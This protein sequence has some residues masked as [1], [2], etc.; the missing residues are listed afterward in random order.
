MFKA[1][2]KISLLI[3]AISGACYI[4]TSDLAAHISVHSKKMPN[5]VNWEKALIINGHGTKTNDLFDLG[6]H[7]LITPD[8]LKNSYVL[9]FDPQRNLAKK[10]KYGVVKPVKN[11]KWT[12]YGKQ[13]SNQ[14]VPDVIIV[15]WKKNELVSFS[16]RV[17]HDPHIWSDLDGHKGSYLDRDKNSQLVIKQSDDSLHFLNHLQAR[18]YFER[19][20]QKDYDQK[21]DGQ[22]IFFYAPGVR[23]IKILA[24]TRLSEILSA[25]RKMDGDKIVLLIAS[26]ASRS[27]NKTL[28]IN[29]NEQDLEL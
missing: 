11:G 6:N 16:S 23:K 5:T 10:I 4:G 22:P 17:L 21:N 13:F 9:K 18:K 26:N 12:Y 20:S 3:C 7:L 15:P 27:L 29:I 14:N 1:L 25:I 2:L 24:K 8:N 19:I 28:I